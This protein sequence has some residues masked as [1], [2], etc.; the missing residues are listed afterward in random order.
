MRNRD[1]DVTSFTVLFHV[2]RC[3]VG[4]DKS[5][6]DAEVAFKLKTDGMRV[7]HDR[8]MWAE[9]YDTACSCC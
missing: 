9:R 3:A 4:R 1:R 7:D 8:A 2:V 5:L 6:V